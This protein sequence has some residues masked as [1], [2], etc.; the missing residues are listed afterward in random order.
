MRDARSGA[1]VAEAKD[2]WDGQQPF[3]LPRFSP[4]GRS[5]AALQRSTLV[6]YDLPSHLGG[7]AGA[8]AVV[9]PQKKPADPPVAKAGEPPMLTPKWTFASDWLRFCSFATHPDNNLAFAFGGTFY[10]PASVLDLR[11][12]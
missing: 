9:E 3:A 6:L 5:I 11:T 1:L 10:G 4:D 2:A 7:G 12:G 8:V